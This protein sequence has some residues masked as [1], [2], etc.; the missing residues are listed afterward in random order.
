MSRSDPHFRLRIPEDLKREI[1][2]AARANSRTITSEVVYRLEQSF[3]RSST[4][5]GGLVDEIEAIRM[6]LA[7]VQDLL[8]K[9]ELSTRSQNQDA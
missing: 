2:T 1:E 9:Q 4:D 8:L 7:Y 3:V 6:R 5:K